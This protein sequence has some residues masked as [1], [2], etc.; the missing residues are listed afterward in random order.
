M[1]ARPAATTA[2]T[3]EAAAGQG[4]T[5]TLDDGTRIKL[6][7]GARVSL[8][9]AAPRVATLDRGEALFTVHHDAT[10]PFRVTA[11]GRTIEDVGTVFDVVAHDRGVRVAV[12]EGSVAF[13]AGDAAADGDR[14][15]LT[16][17]MALR[18]DRAG[19]AVLSRVDPAAIG[20]WQHGHL[21]FDD[22]RLADVAEELRWSTGAAI[23]VA[24]ALADTR[25]SG[26]LRSDRGAEDAARSLA[27]LSGAHLI[28][29]ASGWTLEGGGAG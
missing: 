23:R 28:R 11:A 13:H 19:E 12:A 29:T 5:V 8:D 6:N 22:A 2:Y 4:R 15:V 14:I 17:G 26:V 27:A 18:S 10:D 16:P 3:I 24:P 1:L 25:F 20:G 7:G 9:H 21:D